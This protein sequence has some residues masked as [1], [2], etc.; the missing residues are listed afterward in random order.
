MKKLI[1]TGDAARM[2]VIRYAQDAQE[3]TVVTF[4]D[5]DRTLEQNAMFHGLCASPMETADDFRPCDGN[6]GR[7]SGHHRGT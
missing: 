1:I 5:G 3:G 2:A 7:G 6:P 4:K